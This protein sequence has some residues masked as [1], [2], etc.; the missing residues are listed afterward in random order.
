M[1]P[2]PAPPPGSPA[3]TPHDPS[4]RPEAELAVDVRALGTIMRIQTPDAECAAVVRRA[5]HLALYSGERV[6]VPED[7]LVHMQV[8]DGGDD[9]RSE[10]RSRAMVALTQTLTQ[11]AL[12]AQAGKAVFLHAGGLC[13]P[14]TGASFVYVA[15][16]GTGKTT[17]TRTLG[18]TFAY[19]SDETIAVTAD[20]AILPYLKPL[21]VRR[22]GLGS[23]KDE[24]AP[25]ELG[26]MAPTVTPWVAGLVILRRQEGATLHVEPVDTLDA[27]VALSPETSAMAALDHPLRRVA[28]VIE[29]ARGLTIVTYSEATQLGPMVDVILS[30]RR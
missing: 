19:L 6:D 23:V 10:R 22:G 12:R 13:N 15:P 1:T 29:R 5:W 24:V 16:G 14:R 21:S 2:A 11:E 4:G 8:G 27:I 7:R 17:L 30:R 3:P 25:G 28:H 18:R 26:L 9:D 20:G